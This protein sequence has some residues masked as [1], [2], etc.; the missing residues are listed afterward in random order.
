MDCPIEQAKMT[1]QDKSG[2]AAL[3]DRLV[4]SATPW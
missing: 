4:T 2:F 1:T 3:V